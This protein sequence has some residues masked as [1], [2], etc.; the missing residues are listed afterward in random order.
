M[1]TINTV[2]SLV[3]VVLVYLSICFPISK[4]INEHISM[5]R[6][7]KIIWHAFVWSIP[8]LGAVIANLYFAIAKISSGTSGNPPGF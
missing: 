2:S 4:G 1:I 6:N 7:T 8:F 5:S 3:L